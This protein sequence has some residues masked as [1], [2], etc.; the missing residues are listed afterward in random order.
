[1]V[2]KTSQGTSGSHHT[3]SCLCFSRSL[4]FAL[5]PFHYLPFLIRK[6]YRARRLQDV[7]QDTCLFQKG[8]GNDEGDKRAGE[9]APLQKLSSCPWCLIM[10]SSFLAYGCLSSSTEMDRTSVIMHSS[11]LWVTNTEKDTTTSKAILPPA[12]VLLFGLF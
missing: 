12:S 11:S 8:P 9:N 6:V 2:W 10:R 5:F 4:V 3:L 1:M 7:L